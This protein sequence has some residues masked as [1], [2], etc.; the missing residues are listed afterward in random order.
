MDKNLITHSL[1]HVPGN[2]TYY[3]IN[4]P[5]LFCFYET[6]IKNRI[7]LI[8]YS[9]AKLFFQKTQY[10]GTVISRAPITEY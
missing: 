10:S 7:F 2:K 4:H 9:L 6:S 8:Y 5:L 1:L 3:S